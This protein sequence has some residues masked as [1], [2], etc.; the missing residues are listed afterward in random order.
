M[1]CEHCI[2]RWTPDRTGC[3]FAGASNRTA[4]ELNACVIDLAFDEGWKL[5]SA[6]VEAELRTLVENTDGWLDDADD[7]QWLTDEARSAQ[8]WL[9][10]HIAPEGHYF[11]FDEGFYLYV[12]E[13]EDV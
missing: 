10:E 12:S 1:T 3:I 6:E 7:S 5:D 13:D 4:D 11:T 2:T 8:D 9:N